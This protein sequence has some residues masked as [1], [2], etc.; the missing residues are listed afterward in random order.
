MVRLPMKD[1]DSYDAIAASATMM[2]DGYNL[3]FALGLV[4]TNQNAEALRRARA[5]LLKKVAETIPADERPRTVVVFDADRAP[6][7]MPARQ[8]YHEMTVLFAVDHEDADA[9][10]VELIAANSAPRRLTVVSSDRQIK[11][12]A[13]RRRAKAIDSATWYEAVAAR[14]GA[15]SPA[16]DATPRRRASAKPQSPPTPEEVESWL[17]VFGDGIGDEATRTDSLLGPFPSDYGSDLDE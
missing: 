10:I 8:R 12:A 14:R 3:L 5:R 15:A 2:I 1:N 7:G 16:S 4:G 11:R 6:R 13:R 9:L 17:E